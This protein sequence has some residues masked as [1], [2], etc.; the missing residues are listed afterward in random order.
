MTNVVIVSAA[1]TAVG[2]FT[3]AFANTP[4]HDLGAA[5]LD[6]IV[7]RAGIDKADV[8]ETILGQVLTAGQGQNPARQAHI[9]AGLPQESAA[10]SINQVCGSGLRAVALAAQHIQLGDASHRGGGRPGKH[11]AVPPCRASARRP[12]DGRP[13]LHRFDDQGRAV[14]R[15]QRLPHGHHGRK[16]RHQVA[17]F[18]RTAGHLRRR[19]PEQ[20][21]SRAEGGQVQ[22]RNHPLHHQDPQGRRDRGRRRI[23]PP[24]RHDGGDGQ[25]APRLLQG[26][27]RDRRQCLRPERWRGGRAADVGGRSGKARAEAAGANRVLCDRRS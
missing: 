17:D 4:A 26:R 14:G 11:V 8:S 12:E 18:A 13:E 7:T 27:H 6:A 10:W 1:R 9:N 5:V 23:H 19:Q 22:G 20:G 21:R 25:T 2:S 16:R 15:V 24:R 3:G